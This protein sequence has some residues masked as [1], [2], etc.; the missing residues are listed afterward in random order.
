MSMPSLSPLRMMGWYA[1]AWAHT[2]PSTPI[3]SCATLHNGA[4][5]TM[6]KEAQTP[7]SNGVLSRLNT[8]HMGRALACGFVG[9]WAGESVR[10]A[11]CMAFPMCSTPARHV[12]LEQVAS[13]F[14]SHRNGTEAMT[15]RKTLV[16]PQHTHTELNQLRTQAIDGLTAALHH[17]TS[18]SDEPQAVTLGRAL[19]RAIRATTTLKQACAAAKEG[20]TA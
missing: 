4:E 10:K 14:P 15:S 7:A 11:G 13:G 1:P 18:P 2:T 5:N 17:L 8:T 19:S 6:Y 9:F 20:V 3:P 16:L 12:T